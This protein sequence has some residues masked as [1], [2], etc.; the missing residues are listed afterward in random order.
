MNMPALA[1]V[2][3]DL[4]GTL[5]DSTRDIVVAFNHGLVSVGEETMSEAAVRP[6]IGTPLVDMYERVLG[7]H[8]GARTA[9]ACEAYRRFYFDHCADHTRPFPGVLEALDALAGSPLAVA[10][11]K[12]TFMAVKLLDMLGLSGRFD[13]IQGTDDIPAKPDP[14][15]LLQVVEK[16]GIEPTNT[17]MIGDTVHDLSAARAAGMKCCAVTYGVTEETALRRLKPDIVVDNL[18]VFSTQMRHL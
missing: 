4:D 10:T 14:A 12:K 11:T 6:L 3:F 17:W 8:D 18:L 1:S 7:G 5:V 13:L 16:L 9:R 2:I 15:V